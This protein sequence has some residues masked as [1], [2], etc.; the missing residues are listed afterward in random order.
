M[1]RSLGGTAVTLEGELHILR[2]HLRHCGTSPH[3]ADEGIAHAVFGRRPG[4][5]QAVRHQLAWHRLHHR[6]MHRVVEHVGVTSDGVSAGSNHVGAREM[7]PRSTGPRDRRTPAGYQPIK[8]RQ[9]RS[10]RR[11]AISPF[12]GSDITS[13]CIGR[14]PLLVEFQRRLSC[15]VVWAKPGMRTSNS[16]HRQ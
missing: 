3:R 13:R 1:Q 5:R 9:P 4:L 10:P 12:E 14:P 7:C 6:I 8:G 2:R 11:V 16:L 15:G